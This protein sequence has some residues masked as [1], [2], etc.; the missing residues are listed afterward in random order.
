MIKHF[1]KLAMLVGF[2]FGCIVS[3]AQTDD[4]FLLL[5]PAIIAGSLTCDTGQFA[6]CDSNVGCRKINGIWSND[7]CSMK[8]ANQLDTE[9]LAGKWSATTSFIGGDFFNY[10]HFYKN[11]VKPVPSSQDYYIKGASHSTSAYSDAVPNYVVGSYDS[12]NGDWFILDYWGLDIGTIS[13]I[14]INRISNSYFTGCEF[15]INYPDLTYQDGICN[16]IRMS[17][18]ASYKVGTSRNNTLSSRPTSRFKISEGG[19]PA[20]TPGSK[21]NSNIINL[22]NSANGVNH[23]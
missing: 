23:E 22:I 15:Y 6:Q 16:P 9:L 3:V 7:V 8:P 21:V 14:E 5:V 19:T 1:L 10:L 18:T 4:D 11:T 12:S 13:S 20:R 17:K 2:T